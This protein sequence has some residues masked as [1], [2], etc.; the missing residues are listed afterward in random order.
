MLRKFAEE[1]VQRW[2]AAMRRSANGGLR[3]N[4]PGKYY[5]WMQVAS[6]IVW[7]GGGSKGTKRGSLIVVYRLRLNVNKSYFKISFSFKIAETT[8]V[9]AKPH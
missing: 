5:T 6:G 1:C 8:T 2:P 7:L 3:M 4:L 9:P